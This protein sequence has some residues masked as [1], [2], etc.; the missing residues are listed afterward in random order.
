[1]FANL[2]VTTLDISDVC[3]LS[4]DHCGILNLLELLPAQIIL[5]LL[6]QLLILG[7]ISTVILLSSFVWGTFTSIDQ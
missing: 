3:K 4:G 7:L 6:R 2:V 5:V 1:M